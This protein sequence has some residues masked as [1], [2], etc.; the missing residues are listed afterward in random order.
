MSKQDKRLLVTVLLG[1]IGQHIN[2]PEMQESLDECL[3]REEE[4]LKVQSLWFSWMILF[5]GNS[6]YSALKRSNRY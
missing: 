1:F 2:V 6:F 3:L 5:V 4:F